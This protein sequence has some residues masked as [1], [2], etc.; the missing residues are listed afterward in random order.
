MFQ[1]ESDFKLPAACGN[2]IENCALD[3]EQLGFSVVWGNLTGN[4][5]PNSFPEII[6]GAPQWMPSTSKYHFI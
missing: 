4:N 6:V 5:I 2:K 3:G 1:K